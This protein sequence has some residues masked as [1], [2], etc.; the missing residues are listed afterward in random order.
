[1]ARPKGYQAV[2]HLRKRGKQKRGGQT[3]PADGLARGAGTMADHLDAHLDWMR[4]RNLSGHTV[5]NRR[6]T[7]VA[8]MRW[9][10]ERGL[11]HPGQITR[12][13]LESYQRHLYR[14]RKKNGQPLGITT[15]RERLVGIRVF[16]AWLCRQRL[17][18]ANPASEL[19]MPKAPKMIPHDT[20]SP[21][22]V[23][24]I[25]AVPD[26]ADPLGLRD[27]AILELFYS[28]GMRRSELVKLD[29][30]DL[31]RDQ[32][33]VA[34]RQGK[35]M[36]DRV[37]PI[38]ARALRWVE[39]YLDD[40]RPLLACVPGEQG[41]FISGYGE[42]FHPDVLTRLVGN[43]IRNAGIGRE[44]GGCHLLRHACA[45][46]MLEGGADIRYIQQLLGHE[47]LETTAVYTRVSIRQLQLIH[48][49]THP[50]ESAE[51]PSN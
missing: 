33:I 16:F 11:E 6:R 22:E 20:P 29:L 13:I 34:I 49:Q 37:V 15:Q 50:A 1:M 43:C 46:H 51:N 47:N 42:G 17:L 4:L 48:A 7:L 21:R 40:V 18:E 41:L 23:E 31:H 2:S 3:S 12:S 45:T 19:E 26:I 25:L 8:F 24:A 38:G 32:R 30:C 14:Y 28:T 27:R 44:K 9:A 35:G 36:K 10:Q 39:K 5:A